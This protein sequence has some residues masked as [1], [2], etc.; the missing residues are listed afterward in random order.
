MG[1]GVINLHEL[2]K[3]IEKCERLCESFVHT[4][5]R[6]EFDA[7]KREL[8]ELWEKLPMIS[9]GVLDTHENACNHIH[10]TADWIEKLEE[11]FSEEK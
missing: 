7:F 10:K 11:L 2:E 9:M 8:E 3:A 6:E 4:N 1:T 5:L